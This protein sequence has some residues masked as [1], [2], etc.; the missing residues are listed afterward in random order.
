MILLLELGGNK[1]F[2]RWHAITFEHGI[3]IQNKYLT[4]V[5]THNII[6]MEN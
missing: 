3:N 1:L 4:Q 6:T 5:K 2:V